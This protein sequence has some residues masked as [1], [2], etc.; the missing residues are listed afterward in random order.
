MEQ[1]W[2]SDRQKEHEKNEAE[3]Y[4]HNC[5]VLEDISSN[6][7]INYSSLGKMSGCICGPLLHKAETDQTIKFE[8]RYFLF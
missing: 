3:N 7:T 2:T 6:V 8:N 4:E 5:K 1:K